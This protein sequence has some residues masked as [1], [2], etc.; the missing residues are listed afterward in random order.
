LSQ[1]CNVESVIPSERATSAIERPDVRTSSSASRRNSSGY[2]GRKL[3][4]IGRD[5]NRAWFK[6]STAVCNLL[7]ITAL[8]AATT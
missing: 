5:R 1:I 7:R 8:D 3:R 4:Y 6:M 2:R